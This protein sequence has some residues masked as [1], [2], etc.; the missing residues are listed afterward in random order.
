[1]SLQVNLRVNFKEFAVKEFRVEIHAFE[2]HS[3]D[4]HRVEIVARVDRF[5]QIV[6][7]LGGRLHTSGSQADV[8]GRDERVTSI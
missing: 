8:V 2:F 4:T 6:D 7:D 5:V 1:M 3:K